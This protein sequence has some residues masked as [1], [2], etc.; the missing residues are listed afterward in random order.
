VPAAAPGALFPLPPPSGWAMRPDQV[1]LYIALAAEHQ[2][3]TFDTTADCE[4]RRVDLDFP[5]GA[6]AVQGAILFAAARGSSTVHALD[7]ETGR[8]TKSFDLGGGPIAYLA[9]HPARG[10][11][12]AST[13]RA[14]VQ[15]LDPATGA[16]TPNVGPGLFLA[17]DPGEGKYL[18]SGLQPTAQVV[19]AA[20]DG[21]DS[22]LRVFWDEWGRRAVL[23]KYEVTPR[24]LRLVAS[25]NN[26]AVNGWAMHLTPDGRRIMMVGGG[27][28]RPKESGPGGGLVTAVYSTDD[29][30]TKLGEAPHGLAIAFHPTRD[31]GV[32]HEHGTAL[33]LIDGHTFQTKRTIPLA[34]RP[35]ARPLLLTFGGGGR[36]VIV[37]NG[38]QIAHRQGLH[39]IPLD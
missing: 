22:R 25:Q 12:F 35:D 7:A 8:V 19:P 11:L 21:G 10:P 6:L 28:W 14:Q 32:V 9:C 2:I 3:V 15:R 30:Q 27:G 20:D 5:P 31:L 18:Y 39:F 23:L 4:V 13:E 29:L 1:T 36:K 26:A 33:R 16:V 34:D 37:W 24:G 38:E 17:V